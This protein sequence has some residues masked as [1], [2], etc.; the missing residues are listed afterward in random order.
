MYISRLLIKFNGVVHMALVKKRN[1]KDLR[2]SSKPGNWVAVHITKL[3]IPR[4]LGEGAG[5]RERSSLSSGPI[6]H[7]E[8]DSS[9][10]EARFYAVLHPRPRFR[11]VGL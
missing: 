5:E 1:G 2:G 10:G 4:D 7:E 6:S 11:W 8:A 9:S 3:G